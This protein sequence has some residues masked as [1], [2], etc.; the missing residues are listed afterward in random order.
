MTE[1]YTI[2]SV[3]QLY[4]LADGTPAHMYPSRV[5]LAVV[6]ESYLTDQ[7]CDEIVES[8]MSEE[9]YEFG[10]CGAVT[11]EAPRPLP[12]SLGT[13]VDITNSMNKL[14]FG[15]DLDPSP[16]AWLQTYEAGG[17]YHVHTDGTPGNGR[18]LTSVIFLSDPAVFSGGDLI[19]KIPT[20]D[21]VLEKKRGTIVIFPS[22][23]WHEV[24][25]VRSGLRQTVNVGFWG[26]PFK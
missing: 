14:W 21:F 8:L 9:P 16:S 15:F 23:L 12:T 26:P 19:L 6:A 7:E 13:A 1:F 18:K 3:E 25:P 11:R 2:P 10:M 20:K 22:W 24:T 4:R 5:P 17:D